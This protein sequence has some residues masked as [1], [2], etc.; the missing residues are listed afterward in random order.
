VPSGRIASVEALCRWRHPDLGMVAPSVFIPIAEEVG[1]IQE[2]GQFM[3]EQSCLAADEWSRRESPIEVSVNVS[4]AQLRTAEF[5]DRLARELSRLSL[6][7]QSLTIEIT[8]SL[9]INDL[10]VVVHRLD[11]L[12]QLGLGVSLDDFGSGHSSLNMVEKLHATE[13]KIDQSLVRDGS[14]ETHALLTAVVEH[15]HESGI[16]VVAEGVET[17]EQLEHVRELHCDRV[18]GYLLGLP[19]PKDELELLLAR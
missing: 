12:R 18:Q 4:P 5:T 16:R 2:I 19:M 15:V 13:L 1:L 6:A 7:P 10:D 9:P 17:A 14:L 11:E 3:V 8:E